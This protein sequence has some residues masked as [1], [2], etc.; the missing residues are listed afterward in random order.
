MEALLKLGAD[1]NIRS[2]EGYSPLGRV[3]ASNEALVA[4]IK[5]FGGVL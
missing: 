5:S 1:P 3:Q 4:L 2:A